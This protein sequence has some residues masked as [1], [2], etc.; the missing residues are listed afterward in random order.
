MSETTN[1]EAVW[2]S[3][4]GFAGYVCEDAPKEAAAPNA[5]RVATP[6]AAGVALH[7]ETPKGRACQWVSTP[8]WSGYVCEEDPDAAKPGEVRVATP[9]ATQYTGLGDVPHCNVKK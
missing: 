8:G 6:G 7:E 5:T 9:G 4:P 3:T 1:R 2:V